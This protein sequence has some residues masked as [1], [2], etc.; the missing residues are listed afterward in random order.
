[1]KKLLII[2]ALVALAVPCHGATYYVSPSGSNT[3]PYDTWAKAALKPNTI[4]SAYDMAP[5]DIIE[6]DG[7][8]SGITYAD[9]GTA[10]VNIGT[11]DGGI[12]VR[13]S[14]ESGHNGTVTI[15]GTTNN[16]HAVYLPSGAAGVTIERL[17][18]KASGAS[19]R[20]LIIRDSATINNVIVE[21]AADT[22]VYPLD[23]SGAI[24]VAASSISILNSHRTAIGVA[25]GATLNI[26]RSIISGYTGVNQIA[27]IYV[28]NAS[29]V[30]S[31]H[32]LYT[33]MR[34][35]WL[36]V[37]S[38][39][40]NSTNDIF[41]ASNATT[42][43]N[44]SQNDHPFIAYNG[45]TINLTNPLILS[46]GRTPDYTHLSGT[47]GTGAVNFTNPIYGGNPDWL[48]NRDRGYVG[49]TCDSQVLS[50]VQ[51]VATIAERYGMRVSF[52]VN[53]YA[54]ET[55]WPDYAAVIANLHSRGHEIVN[56]TYSHP[57]LVDGQ[58]FTASYTGAGANPRIVVAG[59][60]PNLTVTARTD[61]GVDVGPLDVTAADYDT[62]NEVR[63][64]ID[65]HADWSTATGTGAATGT[66][67]RGLKVATTAVGTG[68]SI[69]LDIDTNY[70]HFIAEI[71]EPTA[72]V[73]SI[74]GANSS[75]SFIIP[76]GTAAGVNQYNA[77]LQAWLLANE[78]T[79]KVLGTRTADYQEKTN[80]VSTMVGS[81]LYIHGI[82]A[83]NT[84]RIVMP[85]SATATEANIRA[86]AM[87]VATWFAEQ[88]NAGTILIHE[89]DATAQQVDY[90]LSE[91][92]KVRGNL[93]FT[94]GGLAQYVRANFTA[95]GSG[96]YAKPVLSQGNYRLGNVSY[97][98][99]AGTA[100]A[101]TSDRDGYGRRGFPDIGPYEYQDTM[102]FAGVSGKLSGTMVYD[103]VNNYPGSPVY[104]H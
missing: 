57:K 5:G 59:T 23:I 99:D 63:L 43:Q 56:H 14:S 32:N 64:A 82:G 35:A 37:N 53:Q 65:A 91:F 6:L 66:R 7:G 92:A 41:A 75:R 34:R 48:T 27:A 83:T 69:P 50:Y 58:A 2:L 21:S 1:M 72:W 87:A 33:S 25:S 61:A 96:Y 60:Y 28:D 44:D 97:A 19:Q 24:T 55:T 51:E 36:Y 45:A 20:P 86:N 31:S 104:K 74:L 16:N 70:H 40:V 46:G 49:I 93:Y 80:P 38:G 30:N 90:I 71:T 42:N 52:A 67:S 78:A 89:A 3:A 13:G 79:T 85:D 9:T 84:S 101:I 103:G 47:S 29:T 26:N 12:T 88:G 77:T 73:E 54:L 11:N 76:F 17:T 15:A 81:N 62:L 18:V 94:L 100:S 95:L 4:L 10:V 39:T 68:T 8:T 22:G 98:I 102:V